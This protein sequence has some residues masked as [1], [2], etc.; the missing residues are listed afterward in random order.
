MEKT[1]LDYIQLI[2]RRLWIIVAFVL[3]SCGTTYYVSKNFVEPVYSA[4]GQLLVNNVPYAAEGNQLNQ[5]NF[6]LNLIE[7]YK[8][9]LRS[10]AIMDEVVAAHPEFGMTAKELSSK[11]E[12]RS[13]DKSQVINLSIQDKSYEQAANIVNA[14]SQT[15]IRNVPSLMKLDNV[16]FLTPADPN[17]EAVP[18]NGGSMM[19]I[20]ISFV[21]SLMASLGLILLLETL[22]NTL[23]TEKEALHDIGLP[24]IASVPTIRKR[25]M[26]DA[27]KS[28]ARVG[29]GAYV[30][31]E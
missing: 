17:A 21:V 5:L 25:D 12:I 30:A 19:N 18:V 26:G 27:A 24:V 10:P 13:S 11:L 16:S 4:S 22:N 28:K 23:R 29:E 15:F 20:L 14:V 1:I 6:S 3:I 31:V 2:K 8:D 7:S 9:I